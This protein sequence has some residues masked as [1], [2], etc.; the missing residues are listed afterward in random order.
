MVVRTYSELVTLPHFQDRFN[1][2]KLDGAVGEETFGDQRYVN[3]SFYRSTEWK[4][5]RDY[6]ISR[7]YGRDLAIPG[8]E[9]YDTV[10]VHHMNPI[11][12]QDIL[13]RNPDILDPEFLVCVSHDT[14]NAI[15]YG[16][17]TKL[18]PVVLERTPGDTKLW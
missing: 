11:T 5:V 16:D 13:N 18:V 12:N 4:E 17:R 14:H 15:H 10:L 1:Y 2:L 8:R 6:V 3:Q 9:I 7:D